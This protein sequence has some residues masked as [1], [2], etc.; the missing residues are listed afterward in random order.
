MITT[1][2]AIS[3]SL[4]TPDGLVLVGMVCMPTHTTLS[5]LLLS[6]GIIVGISTHDPY[7]HLLTTLLRLNNNELRVVCV[8]N[9][10]Y[11]RFVPG[12][13]H[14]YHKAGLM[15]CGN[16]GQSTQSTVAKSIYIYSVY[17]LHSWCLTVLEKEYQQKITDKA[18]LGSRL[19]HGQVNIAIK[20]KLRYFSL[21]IQLLSA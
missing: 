13:A 15:L 10:C 3:P 16:S 2:W 9:F 8:G 21:L 1:Q 12:H 5:W 19:M 11:S 6:Q 18:V 7:P 17:I 20:L 4:T 14:C